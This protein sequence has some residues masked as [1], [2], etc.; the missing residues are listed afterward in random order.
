V[1]Y[2]PSLIDSVVADLLAELPALLLVGPRSTGKTTTALQWARAVVGLGVPG[3]ATAFR[4]D[5]DAVLRT[6]AEPVLLDE[7]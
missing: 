4:A 3:E 1:A 7:W 2:R 6:L 5:P